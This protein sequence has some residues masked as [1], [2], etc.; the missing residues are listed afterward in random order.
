MESLPQYYETEKN[1]KRLEILKE[2]SGETGCSV[3]QLVLAWMMNSDP[4]VIPVIGVSSI[5]QL[6]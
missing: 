2:V 1:R 6:E 4:F 3:N 5:E